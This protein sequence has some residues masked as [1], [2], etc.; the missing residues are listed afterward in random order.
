[1]SS[2]MWKW[3]AVAGAAVAVFLLFV[4]GVLALNNMLE[5][6]YKAGY[7]AAETTV[8]A[9]WDADKAQAKTA[10][11][12]AKAQAASE[13]AAA[14]AGMSADSRRINKS[15]AVA[16]EGVRNEVAKNSV[17]RDCRITDAGLLHYANAGKGSGAAKAP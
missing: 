2:E 3:V 1:M 5:S 11:A 8:T 17:Y 16:M 13:M 10:A 12:E 4:G 14:V 15:M 7:T 6:Q 9:Q